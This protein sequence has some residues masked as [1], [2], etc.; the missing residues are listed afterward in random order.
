MNYTDKQIQNAKS[1]YSEML[2]YKTVDSYSPEFI[3]YE[4]ASQR[5]EFHNKIVR[6]I[7]NGNAE[8]ARKWKLFFLNQEVK[9][10]AKLDESKAKLSANKEASSP[11]LASVKSAGKKLGDYYSFLK[12][13][14]KF[15]REFFSKKFTQESANIFISL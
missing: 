10:D 9:R 2:N 13:N 3:G 4:T 8:T 11:V 1:A 12:S 15:A 7:L 14:K 6:E 5:C